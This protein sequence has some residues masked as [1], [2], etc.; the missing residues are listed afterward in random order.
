LFFRRGQ[1]IFKTTLVHQHDD[2]YDTLNLAEELWIVWGADEVS[3]I[4]PFKGEESGENL[5]ASTVYPTP[6]SGQ[7]PNE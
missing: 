1:T 6:R 4:E 5:P 7:N 2:K 3:A